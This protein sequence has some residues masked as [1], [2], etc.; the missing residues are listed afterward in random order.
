[1][2]LSRAAAIVRHV[3]ASIFSIDLR[4][5]FALDLEPKQASMLMLAGLFGFGFYYFAVYLVAM[6]AVRFSYGVGTAA[7][8]TIRRARRIARRLRQPKDG[9]ASVEGR[10]VEKR[11][12]PQID[13]A[14]S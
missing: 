14:K 10:E 13:E 5:L 8:A 3:T 7:D 9:D 2:V 12:M 11:P 1:M 6:N 4:H